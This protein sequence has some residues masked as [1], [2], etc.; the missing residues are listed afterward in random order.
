MDFE[1]S[2]FFTY[3]PILAKTSVVTLQ[4]VFCSAITSTLLGLLIAAMRMSASRI[5][6]IIGQVYVYIIRG[7]PLLVQILWLFF[8]I[9]LFFGFN[10][11]PFPA[12][13][14]S[15]TIWGGAYFAEIFRGG[16]NSINITQW[17]AAYSMGMTVFQSFLHII[18]PQAFRN[19]FPPFI[20]QLIVMTKYSSL[21]SV[22]N[23]QEITKRADTMAVALYSPFEI[24]LACG[25]VY[26]VILFTLAQLG[27]YAEKKLRVDALEG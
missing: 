14:L 4:V 13:V 20:S 8:G 19:I 15:M 18:L 5:L 22:I 21:L 25:L 6:R 27:K 2:I 3:L 1:W 26:F 23:V 17:F 10:M 24:Y 11:E 7:V 16:L 12:G 9:T